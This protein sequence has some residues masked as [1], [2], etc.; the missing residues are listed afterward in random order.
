MH[1]YIYKISDLNFAQICLFLKSLEEILWV[2]KLKVTQRKCLLARKTWLHPR[3]PRTPGQLPQCSERAQTKVQTNSNL[4]PVT[5]WVLV[6]PQARP[7]R[8][9]AGAAHGRIPRALLRHRRSV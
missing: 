6:L 7:E 2:V 5:S 8:K 1:V 9:R 4:F 3:V